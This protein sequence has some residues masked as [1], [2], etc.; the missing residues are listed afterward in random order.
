LGGNCK[1]R[2]GLTIREPTGGRKKSNNGV[3]GGGGSG[4]KKKCKN[5]GLRT[6]HR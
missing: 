2:G 1:K 4:N 6:K 3:G 5:G